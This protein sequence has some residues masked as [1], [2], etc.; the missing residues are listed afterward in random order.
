MISHSFTVL[1]SPTLT[2]LGSP[3]HLTLVTCRRAC[4][5]SG[6]HDLK[7][8][9]DD[10]SKTW[11]APDL[12]LAKSNL[13]SS[14]NSAQRTVSLN[15]LIVLASVREEGWYICTRAEEERASVCGEEGEKWVCVMDAAS[16]IKV[17]FYVSTA[18]RNLP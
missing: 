12:S 7:I 17:E 9:R 2:T 15:R 11:I 6:V 8:A 1:S 5:S 3:S 4:V 10:R 14:R 18:Q 13:P 16:L